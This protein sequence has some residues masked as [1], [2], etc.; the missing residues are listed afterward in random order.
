MYIQIKQICTVMNRKRKQFRVIN[1]QIKNL[2][3]M[4]R[5]FV[6]PQISA[7]YQVDYYFMNCY[8]VILL[9]ETTEVVDLKT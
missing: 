2:K 7:S 9:V 5:V 3:M 1:E 8:L 4:F 6:F